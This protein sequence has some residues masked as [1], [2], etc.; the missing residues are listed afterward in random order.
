VAVHY[1]CVEK[2]GRLESMSEAE[3]AGEAVESF[4]WNPFFGDPAKHLTEI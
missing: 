3:T 4:Y 2:E 1:L